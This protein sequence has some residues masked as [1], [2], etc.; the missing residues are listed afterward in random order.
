[1]IEALGFDPVSL[2]ALIART[3]INA[4]SLQARLFELEMS[5]DVSRLPGGL[6]QR[7]VLA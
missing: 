6:F 3:G 4:A 7:Q 5:G 1:L 2:D